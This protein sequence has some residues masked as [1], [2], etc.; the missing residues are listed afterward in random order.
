[1]ADIALENWNADKIRGQRD[2]FLGELRLL[3]VDENELEASTERVI[4]ALCRVLDDETGCW[5]LQDHAEAASELPLTIDT[6]AGLDHVRLDRTFVDE[7]GTRWIIDFKTSAHE[8]GARTAFLDSEVE[9][10]RP[11]LERYADA[12]AAIDRRPIR[13]GL[14]F[15]LL[16]AFRNWTPGNLQCPESSDR[17]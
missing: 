17:Y 8:G 13:V 12:M 7:H 6:P 3:G 16:Q 9:R 5:L 4:E 1:M 11:Q 14:Y 2:R 15:P 10:Y